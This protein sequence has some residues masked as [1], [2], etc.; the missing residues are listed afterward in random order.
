M[1]PAQPLSK[2]TKIGPEMFA[3]MIKEDRE[4]YT[5]KLQRLEE[6]LE[7]LSY[8]K[9][10]TLN[11]VKKKQDDYLRETELLHGQLQ[12]AKQEKTSLRPPRVP[13]V[14]VGSQVHTIVPTSY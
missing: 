11:W 1:D 10:E 9:K 2:L 14:S 6:Q 4:S 13:N 12:R 5:Q 8:E 7:N 3:R